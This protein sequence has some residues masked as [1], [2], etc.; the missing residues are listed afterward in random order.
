MHFRTIN[1]GKLLR[2]DA[3]YPLGPARTDGP[4]DPYR[5]ERLRTQTRTD[6]A[7]RSQTAQ[8]AWLPGVRNAGSRATASNPKLPIDPGAEARAAINSLGEAYTTHCLKLAIE[9]Y[10]AQQARQEAHALATS[11]AVK[12]EIAKQQARAEAANDLGTIQGLLPQQAYRYATGVPPVV[13]E[14]SAATVVAPGMVG[15][16]AA[17]ANARSSTDDA[18]GGEPGR[19]A[20]AARRS[21]D[22]RFRFPPPTSGD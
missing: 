10:H 9:A 12:E 5:A 6:R 4:S 16:V 3:L 13:A 20:K 17:A 19:A 14:M 21:P 7:S 8:F 22:M 18:H 11:R 15:P 2:S 1:P